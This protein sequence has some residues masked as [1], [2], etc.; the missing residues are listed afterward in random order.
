M[1]GADE[2]ALVCDLAETYHIYDWRQLPVKLAATLAAGLRNDSRSV[3]GLAGLKF[4]PDTL[5][6]AM[7]ADRLGLLV[8][9]NTKDGQ[10]NRHRPASLVE[11][12]THEERP[13]FRAFD[14]P[15]DFEAARQKAV[16]RFLSQKEE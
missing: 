5:I 10:K 2:D 3:M 8:W 1:V 4:S 7:I 15:E 11:K 9:Q 13:K 16:E 14:S 12:M 6:Y